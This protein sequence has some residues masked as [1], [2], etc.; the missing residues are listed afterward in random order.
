VLTPEQQL[1]NQMVNQAIIPAHDGL[2]GILTD[3]A[4]IMVRLGIGPLRVDFGD[5]NAKSYFLIEGGLAQMK[6][7]TL[8]ILTSKA[9]PASEI[10]AQAAENEYAAALATKATTPEEQQQ[11][12]KA[13]EA[14]RVKQTLVGR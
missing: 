4:P 10:D 11:R 5:N 2:M 3:R 9:I 8:T 13:L 6:D 7:N 14:A 1:L 12:D